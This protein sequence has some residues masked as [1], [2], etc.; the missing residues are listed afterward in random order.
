MTEKNMDLFCT[1]MLQ[2][3]AVKSEK[4]MISFQ[5]LIV[6]VLGEEFSRYFLITKIPRHGMITA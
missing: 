5:F 6:D 3:K 2:E 1:L 4:K